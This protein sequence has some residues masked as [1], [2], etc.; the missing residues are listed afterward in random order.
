MYEGL[1]DYRKYSKLTP[2]TLV[3]RNQKLEA[4]PGDAELYVLE[5][6]IGQVRFHDDDGEI[7][8][9]VGERQYLRLPSRVAQST[10][11]WSS[12]G[13]IPYT[14]LPGSLTPQLG[15]RS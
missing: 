4:R 15:T 10:N 3:R 9:D 7:V 1:P 2:L 8:D 11:T 6:A 13:D 14:S 5:A 12:G